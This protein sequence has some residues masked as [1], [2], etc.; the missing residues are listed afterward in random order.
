M[1]RLV[2]AIRLR[3]QSPPHNPITQEALDSVCDALTYIQV[4]ADTLIMDDTQTYWT[5]HGVYDDVQRLLNRLLG[6]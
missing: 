6:W 3:T 2:A 5:W 1:E 4:L